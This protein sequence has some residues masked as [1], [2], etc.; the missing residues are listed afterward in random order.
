[1]AAPG[2]PYHVKLWWEPLSKQWIRK[3]WSPS[4]DNLSEIICSQTKTGTSMNSSRAKRMDPN[5]SSLHITNIL[6]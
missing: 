5:R 2:R 6:E 1:M 4:L 3:L